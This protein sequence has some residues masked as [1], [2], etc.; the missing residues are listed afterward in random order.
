MRYYLYQL[1]NGDEILSIWGIW[2][3]IAMYRAVCGNRKTVEEFIKR[4]A[5]KGFSLDNCDQI[6]YREWNLF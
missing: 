1:K 2:S 6:D 3:S 5:L 4:N